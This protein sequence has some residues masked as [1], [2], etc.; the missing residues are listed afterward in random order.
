MTKHIL[1][2]SMKKPYWSNWWKFL[3]DYDSHFKPTK[4]YI[5]NRRYGY[6]SKSSSNYDEIRNLVK[7]KKKKVKQQNSIS[8]QDQTSDN[9]SEKINWQD[10]IKHQKQFDLGQFRFRPL[11]KIYIP[12]NKKTVLSMPNS[13]CSSPKESLK[14]VK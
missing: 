14:K 12:H 3:F 11:E 7:G 2:V 10:I 9:D 1:Q 5:W 6:T 8:F 4:P 13:P